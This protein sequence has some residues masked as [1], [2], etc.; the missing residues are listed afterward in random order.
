MDSW[1]EGVGSEFAEG[2]A[3]VFQ[4]RV[5]G[6]SRGDAVRHVWIYD[7]RAQQSITL[8]LGGPDWRTFS[9]KTLYRRGPWTVEIRDKAGRVLAQASFTCVPA[10]R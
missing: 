10:S 1:L 6:G 5:I 7:G 3:V 4:T 8:R 2:E 9:K